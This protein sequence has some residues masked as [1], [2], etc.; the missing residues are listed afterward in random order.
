MEESIDLVSRLT[1]Y[2][3][4]TVHVLDALYKC[5]AN[6]RHL[7]LVAIEQISKGLV[8]I[9]ASSRE[10]GDIVCELRG[11]PSR[12][13]SSDRNRKTLKLSLKQRLYDW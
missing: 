2:Y 6:A 4:I 11:Y 5:N 7:L 3:P 12:K 13:I 8:K 1:E 10:K 9:V